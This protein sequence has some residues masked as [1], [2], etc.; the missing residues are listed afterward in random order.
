M[1]SVQKAADNA[2]LAA[3]L[4]CPYPGSHINDYATKMLKDFSKPNIDWRLAFRDLVQGDGV[5]WERTMETFGE[6]YYVD[7]V[8]TGMGHELFVGGDVPMRPEH[9][10]IALFDSSGSV[11]DDLLMEGY[12]EALGLAEQA[13]EGAAKVLCMMADTTVR[14]EPTLIDSTN[15][16]FVRTKGVE[17]RGMGGTNFDQPIADAIRAAKKYCE[18]NNEPVPKKFSIAYFGDLECYAPKPEN[19]PPELGGLLFIGPPG[20]A[21]EELK[22]AT[23]GF[24]KVF[25]MTPRK[26]KL[27]ID[28]DEA[29]ELAK[30]SKLRRKVA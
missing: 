11:D 2:Q 19:L 23:E 16:D 20:S 29:E 25:T 21:A 10:V 9:I 27:V 28:L 1:E 12:S 14:G 26:K 30:H 6:L 13:H 22:A 8:D 7:P 5:H 17:R 18:D 15:V 24:A 3:D 4:G